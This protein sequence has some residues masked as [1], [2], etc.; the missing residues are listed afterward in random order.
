MAKLGSI[1]PRLC[2]IAPRFGAS[3]R[4]GKGRDQHRNTVKPWRNWYKLARWE[5]LRQQVF[6]RD[7]YTCQ[8]S[9]VLCI[10][11]HPAPNSPVANHKRRH[12]GDPALFWDI[13]NIETVSKEVHDTI[14][15]AEEA[16]DIKG[17]WY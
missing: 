13:D 11:K 3:D 16:K 17:V 2:G 9:G 15:Q 1:K 5:K 4:D 8:R 6:A 10:G 14:V 7:A 12:N